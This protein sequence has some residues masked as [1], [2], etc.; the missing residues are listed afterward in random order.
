M[1]G[2]ELSI[3]G[4][5]LK[6]C[7]WFRG[8]VFDDRIGVQMGVRKPKILPYQIVG[9]SIHVLRLTNCRKL[10]VTRIR[11]RST[12]L[13][14]EGVGMKQDLRVVELFITH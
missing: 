8:N 6:C 5:D 10:L 3:A 7:C 9:I 11:R 4:S 2:M 14:F 13:A 12:V 1:V